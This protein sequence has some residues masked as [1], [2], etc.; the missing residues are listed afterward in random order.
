MVNISLQ[1]IMEAKDDSCSWIPKNRSPPWKLTQKPH[2]LTL[3][4]EENHGEFSFSVENIQIYFYPVYLPGGPMVENILANAGFH[5]WSRKTPHVAE[6]LTLIHNN[7][8]CVSKQEKSVQWEAWTLQQRVAPT[9]TAVR[10]ARLQQRRPSGAKKIHINKYIIYIYI[11]FHPV[12]L[13]Y[14]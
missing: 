11:Y 2:I 5:P 7:Q 3:K 12:K 6:Q 13:S 14:K 8:A 9:L 4:V 10:K 1:L